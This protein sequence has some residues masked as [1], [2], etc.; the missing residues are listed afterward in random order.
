MPKLKPKEPGQ[1]RLCQCGR[2]LKCYQLACEDCWVRNWW[3]WNMAR[4][5]AFRKNR[6]TVTGL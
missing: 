5:L 3:Y 2:P 4:N 1:Q 6:Q